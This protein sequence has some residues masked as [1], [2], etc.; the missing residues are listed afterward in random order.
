MIEQIHY[1][2]RQTQEKKIERV[3]GKI[4]IKFLYHPNFFLKWVSHLLLPLIARHPFISNLYGRWQKTSWSRH[5]IVPFIQNHEVDT[6]DFL[7]P[8]QTFKNFNDFF[9]R[10]LHPHKRPLYPG[11]R[12]AILPADGKYLLFPQL[13]DSLHFFVKGHAFSLLSLLQDEW[14]AA[15]YEQGSLLIARLSP[16]DYHRFHFPCDGTALPAS[17]LQGTLYSV[18]PLALRKRPSILYEN[19]RVVT[20]FESVHFGQIL[21][22]EV[23][24][25]N[26]GTIHQT[27]T[28]YTFYHKGDEKGYFSFGGSSLILLFEPNVIQFDADLVAHS[29]QGIEVS[30]RMGQSLGVSLL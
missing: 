8:V 28:P 22:I 16:A 21:Y 1:T 15:R 11:N 3:Y 19:K 9:I 25:T 20:P 4:W 23:G 27:F 26:V 5:K 13:C 10:K 24:A 6:E 18:N 12:V 17:S 7:D 2:D 30:G 29:A 14:V